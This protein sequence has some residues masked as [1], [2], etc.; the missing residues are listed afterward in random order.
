LPLQAAA[1]LFEKEH[2]LSAVELKV[3]P[4]VD[5][6]ALTAELKSILGEGFVVENRY[7]QNKTIFMILTSEKWAVYAILLMVLLIASFNMIGSL[8]MLVLEKR[9]DITILKTMGASEQVIRRTYLLEGVFLSGG[10]AVI[11]ITLG[12]LVC[13]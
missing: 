8:S 5:L 12:T 2:A 11:G 1:R 3:R 6:N 4:D 9:K 10:G 13:L 7:E